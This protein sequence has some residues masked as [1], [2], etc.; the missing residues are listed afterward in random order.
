[1]SFTAINGFVAEPM[2][3]YFAQ[4]RSH[5][6]SRVDEGLC[7]LTSVVSGSEPV[8]AL[9]ASSYGDRGGYRAPRNGHHVDQQAEQQPPE[10]CGQP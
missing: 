3:Q 8:A 4:L 9:L 6:A 10:C 1:M 2:R 5:S 7:G